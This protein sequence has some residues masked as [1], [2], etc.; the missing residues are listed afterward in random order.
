MPASHRDCRCTIP[1]DQVP[2]H[3]TLRIYKYK[4]QLK[5]VKYTLKTHPENNNNKNKFQNT[6][7]MNTSTDL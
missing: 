5:G 7:M 1:G 4:K 2:V 3:D 6:Q